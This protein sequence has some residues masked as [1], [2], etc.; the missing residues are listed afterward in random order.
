METYLARKHIYWLLSPQKDEQKW[1]TFS[2]TSFKL[3]TTNAAKLVMWLHSQTIVSLTMPRRE[4]PAVDHPPTTTKQNNTMLTNQISHTMPFLSRFAP[5]WEKRKG[6][7]VEKVET[8]YATGS[9]KLPCVHSS[10]DR[11][12]RSFV[13]PR[14]WCWCMG[15]R[16]NNAFS[17]VAFYVVAWQAATI[18][19]RSDNA[20]AGHFVPWRTNSNQMEFIWILVG[21]RWSQIAKCFI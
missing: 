13:N 3:L 15:S 16:V 7:I 19:S 21:V 14:L 6:N 5:T 12:L 20:N 9:D 17:L 10:G 8:H 4:Q 18:A 2:N 1:E 11:S